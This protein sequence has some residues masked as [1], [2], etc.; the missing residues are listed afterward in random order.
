MIVLR[1]QPSQWTTS[2]PVACER[3]WVGYGDGTYQQL[4]TVTGCSI[5]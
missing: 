3:D 4:K 1:N 2:L 5:D